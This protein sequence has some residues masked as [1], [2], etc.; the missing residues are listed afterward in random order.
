M[1]LFGSAET[2]ELVKALYVPEAKMLLP[3][4]DTCVGHEAISGILDGIK[5]SG[6]TK[7]EI[8]VKDCTKAGSDYIIEDGTFNTVKEDGTVTGKNK[9]L[10]TWK[11]DTDGKWR[12]V[13]DVFNSVD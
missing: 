13:Y 10:T 6:V 4:A 2:I 11:K 9:Y 8:V 3:G 5:G 1:E 12:M 7:V